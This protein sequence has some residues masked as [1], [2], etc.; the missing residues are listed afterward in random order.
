MS[1]M[2]TFRPPHAGR[3]AGAQNAADECS[4]HSVEG[5]L[6]IAAVVPD[7]D[8]V[9]RVVPAVP[10]DCHALVGHIPDLEA[11]NVLCK[12]QKGSELHEHI[13]IAGLG[14]PA[15]PPRKQTVGA[16]LVSEQPLCPATCYL[17]QGLAA[18]TADICPQA[19]ARQGSRHGQH[20]FVQMRPASAKS[21][22]HL[23]R[24][25]HGEYAHGQIAK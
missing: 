17:T 6:R 9:V 25:A 19:S 13:S 10:P 15:F 5:P 2:L 11:A 1:L 18:V 12:Q 16:I 20:T 4:A 3:Q 8:H 21:C 14:N 24:W 22:L 23:K 7:K